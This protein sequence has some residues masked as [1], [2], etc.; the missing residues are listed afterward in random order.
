MLKI[1]F[2]VE[3]MYFFIFFHNSL[4]SIVKLSCLHVTLYVFNKYNQ[5][6]IQRGVYGNPLKTG[7][8][9]ANCTP[10][11]LQWTTDH[12]RRQVSITVTSPELVAREAI[13][14]CNHITM[15]K[16]TGKCIC[17]KHS[18]MQ[19]LDTEW[20]DLFGSIVRNDIY[21]KT[22]A[23]F[24]QSKWHD[25]DFFTWSLFKMLSYISSIITPWKIHDCC[26]HLPIW[27]M[28]DLYMSRIQICKMLAR[29]LVINVHILILLWVLQWQ[30]MARPN[31]RVLTSMTP[32][33][34]NNQGTNQTSR[35]S[36]RRLSLVTD[37]TEKSQK[38]T[39]GSQNNVGQGS[40]YWS[41]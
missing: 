13:D 15:V 33:C 36:S 32:T 34:I 30:S 14:L 8:T 28:E 41:V 6:T 25:E 38:M 24:M 11:L 29:V 16:S 22:A 9:C 27:T 39:G 35:S 3:C 12:K 10:L 7:L 26:L 5:F 1:W 37:P 18:D 20:Q 40:K 23:P 21:F 2:I 17:Q 4:I 19:R 31:S